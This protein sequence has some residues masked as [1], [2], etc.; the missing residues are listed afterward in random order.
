MIHWMQLVA[1]VAVL[2]VAGLVIR[3]CL[4]YWD[5]RDQMRRRR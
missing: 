3:E 4:A 1:D 2:V 5:E